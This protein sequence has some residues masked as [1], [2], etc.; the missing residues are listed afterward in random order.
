M[1]LVLAAASA[2]SEKARPCCLGAAYTQTHSPTQ[3]QTHTHTFTHAR[4]HTHTQEDPNEQER[5]TAPL[6]FC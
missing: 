2:I 1:L 4:T 6:H 5:H 3:S